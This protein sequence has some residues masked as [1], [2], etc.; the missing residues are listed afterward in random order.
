LLGVTVEALRAKINFK[1][2]AISL[3]HGHF[4]PKFLVERVAPHQTV[5]TQRNFVADFLQVKCDFTPKTAILRFEPPLG[6]YGQHTMIIL[7]S[8]ESA[9]STYY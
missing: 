6:A 4:D 3:R 1:K 9:L 2:S 8:L 7:G 5:F